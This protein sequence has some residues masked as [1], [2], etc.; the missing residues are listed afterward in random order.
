M[1]SQH[2]VIG[3]RQQEIGGTY[4][5][6]CEAMGVDASSSQ[7][8]GLDRHVASLR[9]LLREAGDEDTTDLISTSESSSQW[10]TDPLLPSMSTSAIRLG[11][12]EK[13]IDGL[14]KSLRRHIQ[15]TTD[16]L[17][18]M[19]RIDIRELESN[20]RFIKCVSKYSPEIFQDENI[21]GF[22]GSQLNTAPAPLNTTPTNPANTTCTNET[23]YSHQ[24]TTA[25]TVTVHEDLQTNETVVTPTNTF[26]PP[27]P[28]LPPPNGKRPLSNTDKDNFEKLGETGVPV[29][30]ALQVYREHL[31]VE[32]LIELMEDRPLYPPQDD[33]YSTSEAGD[34]FSREQRNGQLPLCGTYMQCIRLLASLENR[35]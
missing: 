13:R 28:R 16:L 9:R 6:Q 8:T 32:R 1:S 34:A 27:P 18:A 7:P 22:I 33:D 12:L 35:H 3:F 20:R 10:L 24:G 21:G 11:P 15:L 23:E 4:Y 31:P 29:D 14:E 25:T 2:Y 5:P 26:F 17:N 19:E 30:A